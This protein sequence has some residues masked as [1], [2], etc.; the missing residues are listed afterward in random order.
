MSTVLIY[1]A[2]CSL[3]C[4]CM[5]WIKSHSMDTDTFEFIAC[6]SDECKSRFPD[7]R[8]EA[9]LEAL[10]LV[11]PD[12]R[13]LAG[14][15]SLPEILCNLRYFRRLAI[16]FKMPI[17]NLLSYFVYRWIANNRYIISRAILPLTREKV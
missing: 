7:I 17:I 1:D 3:C 4:G 16:F 12:G 9:C 13:I 5:N 10:H 15:K 2:K 11:T 14:D 6:Q 8:E